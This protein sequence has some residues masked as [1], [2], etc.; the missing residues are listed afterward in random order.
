M[1]SYDEMIPRDDESVSSSDCAMHSARRLNARADRARKSLDY[2]MRSADE[3]AGLLYKIVEREGVFE[4]G[5]LRFG[6]C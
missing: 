4:F 5:E 1:Q 2:W 3:I 6:F